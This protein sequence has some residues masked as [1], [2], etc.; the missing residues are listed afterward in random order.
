MTSYTLTPKVEK[1][2]MGLHEYGFSKFPGSYE[3]RGISLDERTGKYRTG[4]DENAPEIL[5]IKDAAERKKI[6]ERIINT[7]TELEAKFGQPGLLDAR[8]D[9]FWDTFGIPIVVGADGIAK[10]DGKNDF[11]PVNDPMHELYL[12]VAKANKMFAFSEEE[13]YASRFRDDRFYL[14]TE[15]EVKTTQRASIQKTRERSAR[16]L[17]LFGE[18]PQFDRAWEIAYYID[19]KPKKNCSQE[20]LDKLIEQ[21]TTI[22]DKLDSF[23][24]ACKIPVDEL[25]TSNYV[26]KAIRL[27]IIK[28]HPTD[29]VYYSVNQ[30]FRPTEK[31]TIDY[32][33]SPSQL[34][35]LSR[36][37]EE[38]RKKEE[39]RINIG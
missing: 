17:E 38:V 11:D 8:N 33:K 24:E 14:T 7:R 35:E 34:T 31:E 25:I 1:D 2:P 3:F 28:M 5:T 15:D 26:K 6:Q 12:V 18:T 36:I 16:M 9:R 19:L 21:S 39:K 13:A 27:N 20:T 23:L 10:I 29:K 37:I 30:N 32:L 4:L 22:G